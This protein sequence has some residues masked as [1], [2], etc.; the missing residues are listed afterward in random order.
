MNSIKLESFSLKVFILSLITLFPLILHSQESSGGWIQ[1]YGSPGHDESVGIILNHHFKIYTSVSFEENMKIAVRGKLTTIV[2]SGINDIIITRSDTNGNIE[3]YCQ[4]S[5]PGEKIIREFYQVNDNLILTG[6][7]TRKLE[8]NNHKGKKNLFSI[9]QR[10]GHFAIC[11]DTMLNLLW[12]KRLSLQYK[13]T[14][15]E[16]YLDK[17]SIKITIAKRPKDA[18]PN[19]NDTSSYNPVSFS[20]IQINVGSHKKYIKFKDDGDVSITH[21]NQMNGRVIIV[22][23]FSDTLTINSTI[24]LTSNGRKDI[25]YLICSNSGKILKS[26]S[27]GGIGDDI[28]NDL[29]INDKEVNLLVTFSEDFKI[30][31]ARTLYS[32]GATDAALLKFN[33][34]TN[35]IKY[36]QY[37]G[38]GPDFG[39][40]LFLSDSSNF[41]CL[42]LTGNKISIVNNGLIRLLADTALVNNS[43]STFFSND[44]LGNIVKLFT[45]F[46]TRVSGLY[47]NDTSSIYLTANTLGYLQQGSIKVFSK[48]VQDAY[49]LKV[50]NPFKKENQ[51]LEKKVSK[52]TLL[53][54]KL[55]STFLN[56]KIAQN[57]ND[58]LLVI[59]PNPFKN[60]INIKY[61][62]HHVEYFDLLVY[63]QTAKL[64]YSNRILTLLNNDAKIQFSPGELQSGSYVIK[65]IIP[66][67]KAQDEI[68]IKQLVRQL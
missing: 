30:D 3:S 32:L 19:K 5:G 17:D 18:Y 14:I 20:Y 28:P 34:H 2:K 8:F 9:G 58:S 11:L 67:S 54:H 63:D 62:G 64:V 33:Y 23:Q 35:S 37:G 36:L 66:N 40:K 61:Q 57:A 6:S 38:P 27:F 39:E 56:R 29:T 12:S 41:L 42:K 51:P 48:G 44:T 10:T 68:Y 7:F 21:I 46:R 45:G 52:D 60:L 13:C 65:V 22:G 49:A 1:Q 47:G 24:Q 53:S 55:D 15:L 4:L 59:Y 16:K 43:Q 25:F 50:L 31:S 26:Q